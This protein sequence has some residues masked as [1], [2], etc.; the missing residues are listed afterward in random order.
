MLRQQLEQDL[1]TALLAGDKLQVSVLRSLK[2][3]ITYADVAKG[4]PAGGVDDAAIL[5]IFTKEAK[6]RQES[7][8]AYTQVHSAEWAETE[9]AEKNIIETY[10]P[11]RLNDEEIQALISQAVS[12]IGVLSKQTMGAVIA[13][14]KQLSQGGADGATVARLVREQIDT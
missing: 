9:L 14:V 3:A 12:E 5:H 6:K 8:D 10:L 11:R 1:K 4:A 13:K 7:A 2:S